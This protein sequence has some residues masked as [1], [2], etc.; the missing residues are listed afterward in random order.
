MDPE[1]EKLLKEEMEKKAKM[2]RIARIKCINYPN[3]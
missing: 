1:Q 2:S 3:K